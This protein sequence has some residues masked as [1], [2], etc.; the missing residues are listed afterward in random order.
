MMRVLRTDLLDGGAVV[1]AEIG[2]GF[3]IR[4]QP[5]RQPH[6]FHIAASLTL[7]PPGSIGLG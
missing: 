3:V 4:N 6:H 5:Y 1:F 7:K 2:D